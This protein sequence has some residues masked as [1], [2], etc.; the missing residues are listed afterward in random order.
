MPTSLGVLGDKSSDHD[1]IVSDIVEWESH[2]FRQL[3]TTFN[4]MARFHKLWLGDRKDHRLKHEK[5]RSLSWLGEP[6]ALE[7]TKTSALLEISNAIDPPW[8]AEGVGREDEAKARGFERTLDY[9]FRG[10]RWPYIQE[11]LYRTMGIQ[12]WSTIKTGWRET[13]WTTTQRPGPEQR[14]AFD[15]A[16]NEAMKQGLPSPPDPESQREEFDRWMESAQRLNPNIPTLAPGPVETITYRGPDFQRPSEFDLRFDPFTEDWSKQKRLIHRIL[17]PLSEIE[18]RVKQGIYDEGQVTQ[19]K[20]GAGEKGISQWDQEIATAIGLQYDP[21]DPMYKDHHELWEDWEPGGKYPYKVI[22]NRKAVINTRPDIYPY[23]HRQLPYL[24][25]RN[26]PMGRRAIGMSD[27]AQLEKTFRDRLTFRDLLLDAL[28]LSVMPVFLKSRSLGLPDAMRSIFPGL[29]LEVNDVNGWRTG[30]EAPKGFA[31]LLKIGEVLRGDEEDF[32]AMWG[33]VRGQQAPFGRVSATESSSR[34]NQ[35]LVRQKQAVIRLEEEHNPL[36][37]Q[38]LM[39]IYQKWPED[40]AELTWLKQRIAGDDQVDP[41]EGMTRDVFVE[42][43][44][45]DI[46][47]RGAT[48][49]LDKALQAQQLSDFLTRATSI[50]VAPGV[51]ALVPSEIREMLRRITETLGQKGLDQ[52]ITPKGDQL[53]DR[54]YELTK[55]NVEIQLIQAQQT[56]QQMLNPPPQVDP[57]TGQPI[58]PN[59]GQVPAEGGEM[60]PEV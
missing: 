24:C 49:T 59:A 6:F 20:S 11:Q 37:P 39:N 21:E 52:I 51:M 53:Q 27:Y 50:Q 32:L 23:W 5:W 12:G 57:N 2:S 38:S 46:K 19:A 29:I 60:P 1:K 55:A 48:R 56:I 44:G 33:N 25:L 30:W 3:T 36:I 16:V 8:Q 14:R 15:L 43:L 26:I 40:D 31:E 54:A 42:A 22:M 9:V 47:F 18:K 10:N 35:A 58:D 17:M 41:F 4:N 28:V 7:E 34:V 13:V 45:M